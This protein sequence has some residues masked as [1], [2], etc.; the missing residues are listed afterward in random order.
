MYHMKPNHHKSGPNT[1]SGAQKITRQSPPDTSDPTH[2]GPVPVTQ[3]TP[4]ELILNLHLDFKIEKSESVNTAVKGT[5]TNHT[6]A[7]AFGHQ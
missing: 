2:A 6:P 3:Y 5:R 7:T 1:S 4:E